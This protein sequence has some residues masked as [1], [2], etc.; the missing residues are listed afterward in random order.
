MPR[1][2]K[3][4]LRYFVEELVGPFTFFNFLFQFSATDQLILKVKSFLYIKCSYENIQDV[5]GFFYVDG[6]ESYFLKDLEKKNMALKKWRFFPLFHK[7]DIK[8]NGF[9]FIF[10]IIL[11]NII[12]TKNI[13]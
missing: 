8:M 10:N 7:Y 12:C 5:L 2:T 11:F 13:V 3:F 4:L 1:Y 9:N 6:I